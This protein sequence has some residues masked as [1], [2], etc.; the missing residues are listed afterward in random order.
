MNEFEKLL[1]SERIEYQRNVQLKKFTWIHRGGEAHFWVEPSTIDKLVLIGSYLYSSKYNFHVV[2]Y[3]SNLY[4]LNNYNTDVIISTKKLTAYSF[5]KNEIVCDCG[6]KI[7][8]LSRKTVKLGLFGYEGLIDLP[9]TVGSAVYNN[10]GCYGCGINQLLLRIDLL[11]PDGQIITATKDDMGY[12]SERSSTLKRG[13]LVGIILR[14]YLKQK[15][16]DKGNL[17]KLA[18]ENHLH[19]KIYQQPPAGN[20]G[21]IFPE[22]VI[23]DFFRNLP[24]S[25]KWTVR[26]AT[27][28]S[29][30][31]FKTLVPINR[32][33]HWLI[34]KMLNELC[35]YPYISDYNFNCFL[36]I[37][38]HADDAF[39]RYCKLIKRIS[40]KNDIEIEVFTGEV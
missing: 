24:I 31:F 23:R 22:Y 3:T 16:G 11:T 1:V 14:V 5:E 17:I 8:S 26:I 10:S 40:M 32:F 29:R 9:G 28:I 18:Q 25:V 33:N 35:L 30:L 39:V 19:R 36:W 6:V 2:G 4:F 13:E 20:L 12:H 27:F 7:S 37:D 34:L 21:S 15:K 38:D